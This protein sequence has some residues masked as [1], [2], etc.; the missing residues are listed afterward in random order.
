M[1]RAIFNKGACGNCVF[2]EDKVCSF[3]DVF[4]DR[5][6]G[7][8]T[9]IS[10]EDQ[11]SAARV[12]WTVDEPT[13]LTELEKM[14]VMPGASVASLGGWKAIS[15]RQKLRFHKDLQA[16]DKAKGSRTVVRFAS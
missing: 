1:S 2:S 5:F 15:K 3:V 8:D 11:I 4:E 16:V 10:R 12:A 9:I 13:S 7:V 6:Q 14:P